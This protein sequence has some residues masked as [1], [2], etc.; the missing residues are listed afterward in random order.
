MYKIN[1]NNFTYKKSIDSLGQAKINTLKYLIPIDLSCK[2]ST[3]VKPVKFAEITR[4][5][6]VQYT[7]KK[8]LH[9]NV[10]KLS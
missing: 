9:R 8:C 2:L 7:L 5:I 6:L 10:P 1:N 3:Q 4:V